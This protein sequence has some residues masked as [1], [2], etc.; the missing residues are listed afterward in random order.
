L[1]RFALVYGGI[2]F[3]MAPLLGESIMR[4]FDYA[5]PLFFVGLPQLMSRLRLTLPS[6]RIAGGFLAL[7]VVLCWLAMVFYGA[8]LLVVGVLIYVAAWLL[9]RRGFSSFAPAPAPAA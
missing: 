3:L 8:K 9:V 7:H 5:W 1:L 4:L 6:N 2:S